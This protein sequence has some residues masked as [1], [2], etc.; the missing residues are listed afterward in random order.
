MKN[1]LRR[2]VQGGAV[3]AVAIILAGLTP[4]SVQ[5]QT[6]QGTATYR[7]RLALPPKAAFEATLEDISRAD[8]PAEV[9]GRVHIEPAG[10]VPIHFEISY[11]G[12]RIDPKHRYSVRARIVRD[13]T[14]LFTTTRIYPVLTQGAGTKVELLL[15]RVNQ[16][17]PKS[18]RTLTDTYWKLVQLGDR[19]V[20]IAPRQRHPHLILQSTSGRVGGSGGCNR[21]MGTFTL[22]GPSLSFGR[23]ATTRMACPEGMEQESAFLQ[24][25]EKVTGWQV[26]G[27][28]LKL[29]DTHG[30]TVAQFVAVDLK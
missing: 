15:Q 7:E 21:L 2:L 11:D 30:G 13:D 12:S 22:N 4:T 10:Q 26:H 3:T 18:D 8:A 27:D 9:I 29:L 16:R 28:E 20:Q 19:A 1:R 6:V 23:M 25:L 24:A 5:A 17:P 14:L